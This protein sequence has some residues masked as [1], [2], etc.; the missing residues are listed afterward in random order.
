MKA[1]WRVAPGGLMSRG[2]RT[3]QHLF[4]EKCFVWFSDCNLLSCN[5][6]YLLDPLPADVKC[7]KC[8]ARKKKMEANNAK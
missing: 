6:E 7:K 3:R 2:K 5:P 8:L 4:S 1:K